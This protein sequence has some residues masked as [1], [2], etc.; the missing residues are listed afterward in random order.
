MV[1]FALAG[2]FGLA[3]LAAASASVKP[4][5][6]APT[7]NDLSGTYACEGTNPNGSPYKAIVDIVKQ[8]DTYLVRWTQP[9]RGEVVGIGIQ[10]EGLLAVSYFGGAPALVVYTVG[11]EGRMEG[12]WTMGGAEG[13]VFQETLT[14]LAIERQAPPPAQAPVP[15]RRPRPRN[16]ISL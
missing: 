3:V 6:A 7:A 9:D 8:K 1:R 5:A 15:S 10:R 16:G 13:A 11:S 4:S 14:K 2:T 12:Q